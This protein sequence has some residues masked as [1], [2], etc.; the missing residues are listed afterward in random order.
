MMLGLAAAFAFASAGSDSAFARLGRGH[1]AL[2]AA[3]GES[4][5]RRKVAGVAS[6]AEAASAAV[7]E[8]LALSEMHAVALVA[9]MLHA[10]ALLLGG[11]V[12]SVHYSSLA[13]EM[14]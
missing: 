14:T 10:L 13:L 11:V 7:D 3:T 12:A 4:V 5:E 8:S 1:S 6:L 2:E 9:S